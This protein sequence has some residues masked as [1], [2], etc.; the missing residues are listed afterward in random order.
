[1]MNCLDCAPEPLEA[2]RCPHEWIYGPVRVALAT[3]VVISVVVGSVALAASTN[4]HD[5]AR[6]KG[7]ATSEAKSA[8]VQATSEARQSK[9]VAART[10]TAVAKKTARDRPRRGRP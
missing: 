5:R 2:A 6:A 4:M 3:A 7:R 10:A 1:M 9:V 8:S